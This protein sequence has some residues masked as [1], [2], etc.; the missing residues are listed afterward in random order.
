MTDKNTPKSPAPTPSEKPQTVVKPTVETAP[1]ATVDAPAPAR[2]GKVKGAKRN[3]PLYGFTTFVVIT[4][5]VLL[6][7]QGDHYETIKQ[8][9]PALPE[10]SIPS[11]STSAVS[12]GTVA[13]PASSSEELSRFRIVK[14]ELTELRTSHEALA[15][16]FIE[17]QKEFEAYK[18]KAPEAPALAAEIEPAAP[19]VE[20]APAPVVIAPA[21]APSEA[22]TAEIAALNTRIDALQKLL[23]GQSGISETRLQLLGHIEAISGK[24]NAGLPYKEELQALKQIVGNDSVPRASIFT[25]Q[26]NAENGVP[27]LSDLTSEFEEIARFTV[28]D[29]LNKTGNATFGDKLRAA[30]GNLVTIRKVDVEADDTSDEAD[31]ARAEAELRAGNIEMAVTHLNQLTDTSKANFSTWIVKA[32]SYLDTRAALGTVREIWLPSAQ[33]PSNSDSE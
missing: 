14:Q 7:W 12:S 17:L 10:V 9:I 27:N 18:A 19:A 16:N 5:A 28:P 31:I 1:K 25:L 13:A 29:S 23:D 8:H 33:K 15:R 22:V 20:A 26:Q 3:T 6:V 30:F 11:L 32:N 4:G 2:A 24:L 21:A